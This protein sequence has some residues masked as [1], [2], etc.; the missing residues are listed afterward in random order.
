MPSC[1]C[2]QGH[3]SFH[4]HF[5][6]FFKCVKNM[7]SQEKNINLQAGLAL[8]GHLFVCTSS[9]ISKTVIPSVRGSCL[10]KKYDFFTFTFD[11]SKA[12]FQFLAR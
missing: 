3:S 8:D 6:I 1:L 5:T 11:F 9:N 7:V 2:F 4:A 12:H 10:R